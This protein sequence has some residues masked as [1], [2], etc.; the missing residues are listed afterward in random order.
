MLEKINNFG[1]KIA[2]SSKEKSYSYR[3]LCGVIQNL[4]RIFQDKEFCEIAICMSHGI[5][6]AVY[7]L[8]AIE[9]GIHAYLL[10]PNVSRNTLETLEKNKV[11][12]YVD[13]KN[14]NRIRQI[15]D[16]EMIVLVP[17]VDNQTIPE[18][19]VKEWRTKE[20]TAKIILT[21]SGTT[22]ERAKF[23][24]IP[25]QN[26]MLKSIMIAE[27]FKIQ[28][29]DKTLMISPLC[30][31]QAF[32]TMLIH[33]LKG[34]N[35]F[36]DAFQP[37]EFDTLLKREKITTFITTPAVIRGV[38]KN[39]E[40]PYALRLLSIGGDYMDKELLELLHKKWPDVAYA[41]VYGATETCAADVVFIPRKFKEMDE[42]F[43]SLGKASQYSRV[44][45]VD[46]NDH[47]LPENREGVLCIQSPF[48]IENYY[49]TTDLIRNEKGYFKTY[50]IG[51]VDEK[52][53]VYYKGRASSIIVYNGEKISS[54]EI[55]NLLYQLQGVRE[56]IVIGKKHEIYGQIP[57]AY[58]VKN[59][60]LTEE[61]VREY[62][63][64][65]LEKYKLPREIRFVEKLQ[66]TN[67]GKLLRRESAYE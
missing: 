11:S 47:V 29:S 1:D 61:M 21:T 2:F 39:N 48:L 23:V 10:H 38:I 34:G 26:I 60:N 14:E 9:A 22:S 59:G 53:Y 24:S 37:K 51:Y 41:N 32:W 20:F 15:Y 25:F 7:A 31:V 66:R 8:A 18:F 55:E 43:Y 45:V 35:V 62:L 27:L 17:S 54:Y 13:S 65:R 5:D 6:Y 46:E 56:A 30:F 58:I 44:F 63:E 40:A 64:Q 33:M 42:T 36:F 16:N 19:E 57:I 4:V 12:I 50:D 52:G 3:E 28:E 49:H 67:S